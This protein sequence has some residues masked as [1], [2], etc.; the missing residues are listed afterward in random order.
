MLLQLGLGGQAGPRQGPR[1]RELTHDKLRTLPAETLTR[2]LPTGCSSPHPSPLQQHRRRNYVSSRERSPRNPGFRAFLWGQSLSHGPLGVGCRPP[3][4]PRTHISSLGPHCLLPVRG[5]H[6]HPHRHGHRSPT[7]SDP[8][9]DGGG[10]P[11]RTRTLGVLPFPVTEAGTPARLPA[12][13]T[14]PGTAPSA[15]AHGT[16][17]TRPFPRPEIWGIK[18]SVLKTKLSPPQISRGQRRRTDRDDEAGG[19]ELDEGDGDTQSWA[20]GAKRL[21][22]PHGFFNRLHL[23]NQF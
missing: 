1:L 4:R 11:L 19:P 5:V 17:D 10:R 21:K 6:C 13:R 23:R 9:G 7:L 8:V 20:P 14:S 2:L 15:R 22:L 18:T 16:R 3:S 12:G